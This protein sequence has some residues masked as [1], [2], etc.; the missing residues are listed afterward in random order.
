M[1]YLGAASSLAHDGRMR[2]PTAE[3]ERPDSTST[4]SLWPPGFPAA[5]ALPV[6]FGASPTQAARWINIISAAVTAGAIVML[7]GAPLGLP[8]GVVGAVVVLATQA[9]FDTYISVLSEPLFIALMLLFLIAMVHA[10][11]RLILL[12]VL[13]TALVMVR[14]AGAAAPMAAVIWM[15]IDA[16]HDVR[17][18]VRRAIAV[19]LIPLIALVV[20]F[21]RTAAAPDRHA[22]P[23][24]KLYGDW[25]ATILQARDTIAEW[26]APLLPD[27]TVQRTLALLMVIAL[28]VFLITAASDTGANRLR[29]L[30]VAGVS[31]LI[32]AASL[33]GACYII[34]IL[35]SRAF[36][37]GTIP[38]DWRILAPLIVLTEIA[39]V[40]AVGYWWRAY[41]FPVHAAI[42]VVGIAWLG[43]AATATINDAIYAT[44]EGS[45]FAGANW[46]SS[47]L[48]AWVRAHGKG[49]PL[50][51]NWP[52]ALYFHAQRIA[53]ELPDST[54]AG[55]IS[56]FAA[57]IRADD[58]YMVGF[59]EPS[60][61]FIAPETLARE[62][63]LRQVVRTSDGAVWT[64]V[65][66]T[67]TA[68]DST[69]R[70]SASAPVRK[71]RHA[72][73][74]GTVRGGAEEEVGVV[75][76]ASDAHGLDRCEAGVD[77]RRLR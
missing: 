3:W 69:G 12:G 37:G 1:A 26:L 52:A 30:R 56:G 35:A 64:A 13:A 75:S 51:S 8:A 67:A 23:K 57:Q 7:I 6:Y 10:R 18:R 40:T 48:I 72:D 20:W 68:R 11:D 17:T 16:R 76:V 4:L 31:T 73:V 2:V 74:D 65:P 70:D 15:L 47:P 44:T 63:G 21:A 24:L 50:Y 34:V 39:S 38:L 43:A 32:A 19:G 54:D 59:D 61:D 27:G 28:I 55:D 66:P 41:H 62:L 29:R 60:P 77:Q 71:Q 36:V 5:I 25:G 58:G 14:Y 53:R 46:R 33:F 42:L 45:D 49:H 22:T 9:V